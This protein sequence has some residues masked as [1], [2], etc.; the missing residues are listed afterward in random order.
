VRQTLSRSQLYPFVLFVTVLLTAQGSICQDTPASLL[1]LQRSRAFLD[2]DSNVQ[3]ARGL[4]GIT[5]GNPG[6]VWRYPNSLSCLEVYGDGRYVLEKRD[7]AKLGRPK[8]RRA[9]GSLSAEDFQRLRAILDDEGLKQ[10]ETPP[11][12]D[13]PDDA[14]GLREI[15]S[16]DAAID[17]GGSPQR[18]TIVRRRVKTR[19]LGG[20]DTFLDNGA[21]LQKTL[22]PLTK[23]F[24][25]I[26]K[27][28]KSE[29]KD[30]KPQYC[31]AINVG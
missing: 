7:E 12:A 8:V 26:E 23:W 15:E 17:R 9:E 10:I 2:I 11:I 22:N 3:H 27:K 6:D 29:L 30:A 24:D 13:L 16:L 1:R 18:F 19:D 5:Y 31:I 25:T 4:W 20:M 28:S 14:V 21:P